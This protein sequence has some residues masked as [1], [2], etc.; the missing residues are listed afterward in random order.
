MTNRNSWP[1]TIQGHERNPY[2]R[3][4]GPQGW[5]LGVKPHLTVASNGDVTG[6][7]DV[8]TRIEIRK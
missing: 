6:P 8:V 7:D 5:E 1:A 2:K 4:T 3:P